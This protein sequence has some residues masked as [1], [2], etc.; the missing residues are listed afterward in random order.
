[1]T[2]RSPYPMR[3][4]IPVPT[5]GPRGVSRRSFIRGASLSA[6]ALGSSSLLAACG[7]EGAQQ[8]AESC[9]SEDLSDKEK[10]LNFSNWPEYIDVEKRKINGQKQ[11]VMPTLMDFEEKT[12]IK[13]TYNA[14]INDN[15]EFFAKVRNQL[16]DCEPIGRD[17]MV[18]T[19]W[20][21][22][23]VVSLGWA[24]ELDKAN[25]PN[26]EANLL[27][28]LQSPPW[29][30][31]RKYSVPWQSGFTGL[32]YNAKYTDAI[33]S[34]E[35]M[36]TR[37]DLKGKV[38]LLTEMGDTMGFM[39]KSVGA[40]PSDFT[41]EEFQQALEKLEGY[42]G[43][44]QVR[45][46][47]GNDYIRDLD[48]GNIV[49]A[50]A[51]SGDIMVMQDANPDIKWVGPEEGLAIWSDNMLVPNKA[52]HKTNAEK[53]MDHYY[54][55]QVAAQLAAWVWYVTPVAGA[56]EAMEKVDP[57]LVDEPLIFPDDEFLAS[58]WQFMGLE[59]KARQQYEQDFAQVI[60][61]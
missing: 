38:S 36:L 45:R 50:E 31:D 3:S 7:T 55:P 24:Q 6:L 1:M 58:S 60:G 14:D 22:A 61:A 15:N 48:A 34:M 17:I 23:R 5:L 57:A 59:E 54:D 44:G 39:L 53:L 20:M 10:Q 40:D 42:V 21:A 13:V 28:S 11:T 26:V 47:T 35:E 16:A 56:R 8:T 30:P 9:T 2:R 32:A 37:P 33:S 52:T 43:S 4:N 18:L 19:D 41:E 12:G 27:P 46:F 49:A 51:W 29:D 25:M